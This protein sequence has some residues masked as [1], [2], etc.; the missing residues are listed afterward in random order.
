MYFIPFVPFTPSFSWPRM[1]SPSLPSAVVAKRSD[2]VRPAV[3]PILPGLSQVMRTTSAW[4]G[5]LEKTS[6]V[7]VASPTR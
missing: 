3:K 1:V 2:R 4:S 5:A 6:R 7:N